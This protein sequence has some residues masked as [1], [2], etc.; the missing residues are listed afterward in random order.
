MR[1][2]RLMDPELIT[3]ITPNLS[4]S[5][6]SK[7]IKPSFF[8][9]F[10]LPPKNKREG[11]DRENEVQIRQYQIPKTSTHSQPFQIALSPFANQIFYYF[12]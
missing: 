4:S 1:K 2:K 5:V 11:K 12:I 8:D 9:K 3:S 10:Y 7:I 6:N